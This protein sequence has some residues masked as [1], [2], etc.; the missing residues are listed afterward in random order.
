MQNILSNPTDAPKK[1][2]Q[3]KKLGDTFKKTTD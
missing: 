2:D 3:L 1:I